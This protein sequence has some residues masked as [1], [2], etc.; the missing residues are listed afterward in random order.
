MALETTSYYTEEENMHMKYS[1]LMK[2]TVHPCEDCYKVI[3]DTKG[4]KVLR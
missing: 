2:V 4:I 1:Y 3:M